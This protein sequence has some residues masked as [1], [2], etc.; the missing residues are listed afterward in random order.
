MIDWA[1]LIADGSWSLFLDR[2]GVI[3]VRRIDDYVKNVDEFIFIDGVKEA[4]SIFAKH[5]RHIFIVTNQQGIG[6]GIMTMDDLETVHAEMMR[7]IEKAGGRV[8]KIYSCPQLKSVPDNFR[9]PSPK[10]AFMAQHDFPDVDF[11]KSIMVGDA[12][13]DILFGQNAGMFTV[14]L[15]DEE[16]SA[17]PDEEFHTLIDFASRC[18]N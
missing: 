5:F 16:H 2:D 10:M 1:K 13:S 17:V 7:E 9:K 12:N 15:G 14:F 8:D 18:N 6:K 3:N 11:S 4:L